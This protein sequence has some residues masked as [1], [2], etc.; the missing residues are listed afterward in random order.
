MKNLS[1]IR[2]FLLATGIVAILGLTGMNVYSLYTLRDQTVNLQKEN[3]KLQVTEFADQARNRFRLPFYGIGSKD[4]D[5][6]EDTFKRT[7]QLTDEVYKILKNA[8][9]DSI[10]QGIY[11]LPANMTNCQQKESFLKY[12]PQLNELAEAPGDNNIICDGMGMARTRMRV[13]MEEYNFSNKV[14]FDTHRS[15]TIALVNL[16]DNNVVG[17]LTM[18]INQ[19]Y[20]Q[21]QYLQPMLVE[22]FGKSTNAGIT[23]WLR[24][25]TKDKIIASSNPSISYDS[26][27]IQFDKRFPDFFDDWYLAV[28]FTTDP[29]VAASDRSLLKNLAV[30]GAAV[31]L[32]LGALV[33]MFITAQR[34][35]ELAQRQAG[36]LANV[37]HELKT[38]LAVMQAAGENLADG[39]VNN[40]ERLESYGK[41]IYTES[42]RLR[43]MIEKLLDVAKADS[44]K[45]LAEPKC[46]QLDELVGHYLEEHAEYI[47]SHGFELKTSIDDE[48]ERV[49]VDV[50]NFETILGNLL[51]NAMKYSKDEKFIRVSLQQQNDEVV[52]KITDHGMGIPKKSQ[53]H[54]F[55]KFY[56]AEDVMTANTKGHGLGLSIV[57]NLVELN[58]GTIS[59]KSE[60]GKGSCF[61]IRFPVNDLAEAE[62]E[63]HA[64][65]VSENYKTTKITEES[66]K[67][68][69]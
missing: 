30:L 3:K 37:T 67:Y 36:F 53:K 41:H 26:D 25:W 60:E 7:G 62:E 4:I 29:T 13:L 23:V 52:L 33:F 24:D 55:E 42:I 17:Y 1:T 66:P 57:K 47:R 43:K 21:D 38:P 44:K 20:L 6:L 50:E 12:D 9:A 69:G 54:I 51:E 2:W 8:A 5:K 58:G 28:A 10:Y 34:E 64:E 11:F 56:R 14:I 49:M 32:L 16:K 48:L 31:L 46:V 65:T 22:K 35:R 63:Q 27:K 40:K 18:P 59:V 39:R 61:T 45:S 19:D 68:V 15:M